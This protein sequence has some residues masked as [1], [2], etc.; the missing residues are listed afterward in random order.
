MIHPKMSDLKAWFERAWQP[1]DALVTEYEPDGPQAAYHNI[2]LGD[3]LER[4][5]DHARTNLA[6]GHLMVVSHVRDDRNL[7]TRVICNCDDY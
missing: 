1:T 2:S 5:Y 7:S 4:I 6:F 3:M